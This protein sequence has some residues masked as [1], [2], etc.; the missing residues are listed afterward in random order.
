MHSLVNPKH[1]G[2]PAASIPIPPDMF[3]HIASSSTGPDTATTIHDN[4][5]R[6]R[7]S[8]WIT[9]RRQFT[10]GKTSMFGTNPA[11]HAAGSRPP[12]PTD[13]LEYIREGTGKKNRR[14]IPGSFSKDLT[15]KS[16]SGNV[17][18]SAS[19]ISSTSTN[20]LFTNKGATGST[21][22]TVIPKT[23]FWDVAKNALPGLNRPPALKERYFCVLKGST[24]YLYDDEKQSDP[25]H[26][27]AIDRYNVQVHTSEGEFTGRDGEMFNKKHAV[28]LSPVKHHQESEDDY[29]GMPIIKKP[30]GKRDLDELEMEPWYLFIRNHSK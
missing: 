3:G 13:S 23:T 15:D 5:S 8:G 25:L 4:T 16:K 24:I 14:D 18:D 28:V 22:S 2:R 26:V 29:P 10:P 7:V 17:D 21:T 19:I 11:N 12:N 1:V 20:S 27:I 6:N 9:I 30:A